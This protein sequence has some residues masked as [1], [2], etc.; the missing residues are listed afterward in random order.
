MGHVMRV[1]GRFT[2]YT[3]VREVVYEFPGITRVK[4]D[5]G[6]GVMFHAPK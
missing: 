1:L 6:C 4:M 2:P 3:H 5:H